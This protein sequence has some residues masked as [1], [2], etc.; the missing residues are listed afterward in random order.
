[1]VMLLE[2][3]SSEVDSVLVKEALLERPLLLGPLEIC[4]D[5]ALIWKELY[6]APEDL[7]PSEPE[8]KELMMA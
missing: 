7:V 3:W 1:M 2:H 6:L 4:L 5:E 8:Q